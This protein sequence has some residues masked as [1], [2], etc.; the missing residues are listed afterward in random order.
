MGSNM[1]VQAVTDMPAAYFAEE[2]IAAYPDAKVILT[3]RNV[4][5]WHR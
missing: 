3:V 4:D 2:L 5:D 1:S